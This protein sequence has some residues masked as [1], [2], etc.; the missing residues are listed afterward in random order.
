MW[1]DNPWQTAYNTFVIDEQRFAGIDVAISSL[2]AQ[3]YKVVF[4]STPYVGT[5][6]A[7]AADRT[8]GAALGYFVTDDAGRTVDW[9]WQNG[10]GAMVD[11][12]APGAAAWWQAR[13]ARVVARGAAAVPDG[14]AHGA[15]YAEELRLPGTVELAEELARNELHLGKARHPFRRLMHH[16]ARHTRPHE[17]QVDRQRGDE[18][19][20]EP[21]KAAG[22]RGSRGPAHEK[23]SS[24]KASAS[25]TPPRSSGT[26]SYWA[27]PPVIAPGN[28]KSSVP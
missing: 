2:T 3:G 20:L 9:P 11:F 21:W 26:S 22:G 19:R 8:D 24:A 23:L 12:T 6:A 27:T 7:T 13:I 25:P 10:P 18:R 15:E 4:W 1:I 16:E 28:M 5:T 17:Q 14:G